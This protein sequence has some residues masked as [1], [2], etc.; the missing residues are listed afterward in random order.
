M[1]LNKSAQSYYYANEGAH[2]R[3]PAYLER[4]NALLDGRPVTY[5]EFDAHD[6]Q[7]AIIGRRIAVTFP[8]QKCVVCVP[9]LSARFSSPSVVMCRWYLGRV[10]AFDAATGKHLV[11]FDDGEEK[12]YGLHSGKVNYKFVKETTVLS[13]WYPPTAVDE[14]P[15]IVTVPGVRAEGE[16]LPD[17]D[18]PLDDDQQVNQDDY[19][20]D[21]DDEEQ[22]MQDGNEYSRVGDQD[23]SD[24][25]ID[26]D[27]DLR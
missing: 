15:F 12:W 16:V 10:N 27:D 25:A 4:M 3:S 2:G 22:K 23:F 7:S 24:E 18:Q 8:S 6:D 21:Q 19:N 9:W 20:Q 1:K 13:P 5:T 14:A 26:S 17:D 11:K